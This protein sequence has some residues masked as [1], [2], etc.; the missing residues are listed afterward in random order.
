MR[1]KPTFID[2]LSVNGNILGIEAST[3]LFRDRNSYDRK[4]KMLNK[5]A[6]DIVGGK[7]RAHSW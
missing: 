7:Y 6:L 5:K 1:R 2:V 3:E 4:T